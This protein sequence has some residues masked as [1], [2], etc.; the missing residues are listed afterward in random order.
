MPCFWEDVLHA[1]MY[2]P[3]CPMAAWNKAYWL[4]V[5]L[6]AC[7]L[8]FSGADYGQISEETWIYL[9][10][11]YGGGPEIAIRQNVAQV[12]ELENLHGEQKIEAETRAV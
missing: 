1:V 9:S 6:S 10:T 4:H 11:L 5:C 12:Q 2:Q 8:S 7:L 3:F